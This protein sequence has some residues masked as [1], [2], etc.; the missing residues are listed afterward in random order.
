VELPDLSP[1]Q[2]TW[3]GMVTALVVVLP[4]AILNNIVVADGEESTSPLVLLL[5]ALILL[6]G[7]SGGWAV[8]RLS[9]TARLTHAAGAAAGAYLIAQALGVVL[10]LARGD[11]L[12]WLGYPFLAL[13]M[14]TCGI[15]GGIFARKWQQQNGPGASHHGGD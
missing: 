8:I 6:G 11:Q 13:L 4:V 9:S 15:L 2:A 5:F 3:R 7:A 1:G 14:A 10:R 12:S